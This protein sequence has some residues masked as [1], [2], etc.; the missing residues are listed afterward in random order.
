MDCHATC[1]P[2]HARFLKYINVYADISAPIYWWREFNLYQLEPSV[3]DFGVMYKF[4]D[5]PFDISDF[6]CEELFENADKDL[7]V[8]PK[9]ALTS[10]IDILN[11]YRD[12]YMADHRKHYWWQI[13]QLLPAS[14]I[15]KR[16][17]MMS[18]DSLKS[19][20]T[21]TRNDKCTEWKDLSAWIEKLPHSYLI[22]G[23]RPDED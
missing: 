15:Q 2:N 18:Y 6:S 14:Y 5:K 4:H 20:Y 23:K 21:Y 13:M 3:N 9:M 17:V 19:C 10:L 1:G 8:S 7:A 22:T 11:H 12:L 16:T